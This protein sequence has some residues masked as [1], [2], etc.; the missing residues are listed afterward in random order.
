MF[1]QAKLPTRFMRTPNAPSKWVRVFRCS[2]ADVCM[3]FREPQQVSQRVAR[4][5]K[6]MG[7]VSGVV[8]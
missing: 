5:V 3:V 6:H 7:Y 2:H 1:A 8:C 4:E